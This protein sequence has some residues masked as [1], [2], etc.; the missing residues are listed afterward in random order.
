LKARKRKTPTANNAF[1]TIQN[2]LELYRTKLRT[3]KSQKLLDAFFGA[4]LNDGSTT[5]AVIK[6][7][8]LGSSPPVSVHYTITSKA[9]KMYHQPGRVRH[10]KMKF[11]FLESLPVAV[12]WYGEPLHT[13]RGWYPSSPSAYNYSKTL[14]EGIDESTTVAEMIWLLSL[15]KGKDRFPFKLKDNPHFYL[16]IPPKQP[17]SAFDR[18]ENGRGFHRDPLTHMGSKLEKHDI[19]FVLSDKSCRLYLY[20]D[21]AEPRVFGNLW[22]PHKK[23]ILKGE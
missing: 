18:W 6:A 19:I 22:Q 7:A 3:P 14:S 11:A 21:D 1:T 2:V 4:S 13:V 23:Y 20:S 17:T 8:E 5:G 12:P 15:K 16:D 9:L 10:K